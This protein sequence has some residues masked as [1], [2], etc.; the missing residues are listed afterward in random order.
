MFN[1]GRLCVKIAGRDAKG[2][3]VIIKKIDSNYV[4]IDGTV[5]RRKCNI[6]H[7]EPTKFTLNIK[8]EEAHEKIISKLK[9]MGFEIKEK[10]KKEEKKIKNKKPKKSKKKKVKSAK[11][12]K[13][14]ASKKE[15]SKGDKIDRNNKVKENAE[16]KEDKN[17]E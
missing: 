1:V 10:K 11:D 3:A 5:R 2:L 14:T 13:K 7:L 17:K 8:E 4:L 12:K 16:K 15:D 9:D 6:K